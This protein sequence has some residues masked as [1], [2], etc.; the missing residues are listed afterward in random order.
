MGT[1]LGQCW[2]AKNLQQ[3]DSIVRTVVGTVST[4]GMVAVVRMVTMKVAVRWPK[5]PLLCDFL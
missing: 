3:G 1:R 2:A 4:V 5:E